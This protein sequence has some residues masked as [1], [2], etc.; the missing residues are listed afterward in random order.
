MKDINIDRQLVTHGQRRSVDLPDYPLTRIRLNGHAHGNGRVM[1]STAIPLGRQWPGTARERTAPRAGKLVGS[2]ARGRAEAEGIDVPISLGAASRDARDCWH[3]ATVH[4]CL[5]AV[6]RHSGACAQNGMRDAR[7][8]DA[9]SLM[10][11]GSIASGL[12]MPK[13]SFAVGSEAC[14][15][16]D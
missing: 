10:P 9:T 12:L 2:I 7:T 13:H 6:E 14:T 8:P 11:L 4:W 5:M 16:K 15:G 3:G 1:A